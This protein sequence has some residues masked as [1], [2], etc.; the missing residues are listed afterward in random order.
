MIGKTK[1]VDSLYSGHIPRSTSAVKA[2]IRLK[3][4]MLDYFMMVWM[5]RKMR[6]A[7]SQFV[8]RAGL[9]LGNTSRVP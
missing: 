5:M 9:L 4:S 8:L 3:S 6:R 1:I 7:L 2:G